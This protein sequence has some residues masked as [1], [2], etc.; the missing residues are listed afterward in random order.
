M[1]ICQ[2]GPSQDDPHACCGN[3][4]QIFMQEDSTTVA[5]SY[6]PTEYSLF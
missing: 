2:S 4:I 5:L 6:C 1:R 3:Y